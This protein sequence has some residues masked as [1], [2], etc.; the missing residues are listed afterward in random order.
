MEFK[1]PLKDSLH[2]QLHLEQEKNGFEILLKKF[3]ISIAPESS[4]LIPFQFVA[5]EIG[6]EF[7]DSASAVLV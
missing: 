5:H 1:N 2:V 6:N 7:R 3:R 4:L